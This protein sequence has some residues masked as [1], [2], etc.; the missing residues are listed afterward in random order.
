MST[1]RSLKM[2]FSVNSR[3]MSSIVFGKLVAK[4][5]D[6]LDETGRQVEMHA[7]RTEIIGVQARARSALVEFHQ[8]LAL[9]EPPQKRGQRADIERKRADAQQ[10]IEDA[11]DFGKHHANILRARRRRDAHQLFDRQRESV[12]LAHRRY[13][14]EPVEIGDRL[15]IGLVFDQ[16]LGAAMQQADMRVDALDDLAVHL[17]DEPHHAV[18]RRM[19]RPEIHHEIL[20]PRR[21]FEFARPAADG[22]S[23]TRTPPGRRPARAFPGL[24]VAGQHLVHALPGRQKVEAAKFL[25]QPHRLVDDALLLFVVAQLDIAG[26]RKILAQRMPLE[27]V[28]GQNPAEVGIVGKI[29]AEQIPGLALPPAGATEEPVAVG[30]GS[31]SSVS[32]LTRTRWLR[33]MLNR[34]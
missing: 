21:A 33:L 25:L 11:G 10:V 7:A 6:V 13:V 3:S 28:I 30:T 1:L 8:P 32:I 17:E 14:I 29:D 31:F 24:L 23:L 18:R 2:R 20:D 12:L 34:L 5:Q 4:R 26:Q 27:A 9:L 16:L 15:Q 19:L 22:S